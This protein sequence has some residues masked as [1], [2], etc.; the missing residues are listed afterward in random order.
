MLD[1]SSIIAFVAMTNAERSKAFY[2]KVLGLS[3][4]S[5]EPFSL[6]F[7]AHGAMLRIFKVDALTPAPHTVLGWN[8]V[9]IEAAIENLGASGVVL[10]R[11]PGLIQDS[12]GL[13]TSP[14]GTKVAWFNDPDG[15]ILSLTEFSAE[16]GEAQLE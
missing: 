10:E 9:N 15:N 7:N 16:A 11:F 4:V 5:D 2:Q 8:V 13:W 1:T 12:R 3:L 14:N 6:V